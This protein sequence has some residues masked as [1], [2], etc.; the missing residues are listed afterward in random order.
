MSPERDPRGGRAGARRVSSDLRTPGAFRGGGGLDGRRALARCRGGARPP[1][2][3]EHARRRP[4]LSP[5]RRARLL[6]RSRSR[7]R[8]RRSTRRSPGRSFRP[9]RT[10]AASSGRRAAR[11]AGAHDPRRGRGA[12]EGAALRG[13]SRRL[14]RGRRALSAA[15]GA[16]AGGPRP[17]RRCSRRATVVRTTLPGRGGTV[18]TGWPRGGS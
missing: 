15:L 5:R 16:R 10:S 14:A 13:D 11:H 2:H 9:T 6:R 4:V 1:L 17:T 8:C 7:R 18:A 12:L 3:V